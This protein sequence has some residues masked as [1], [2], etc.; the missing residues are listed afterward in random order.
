MIYA[1][2]WENGDR[3]GSGT[4]YQ[5]TPQKYYVGQWKNGHHNGQGRDV[6][7]GSTNYYEGHFVNG[8]RDGTGRLQLHDNYTYE[9]GWS[10]DEMHGF[11]KLKM[12]YKYEGNRLDEYRYDGNWD[13][14]MFHGQVRQT[15]LCG[16][17]IKICVTI[18][19]NSREQKPVI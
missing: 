1:G 19:K 4:E 10:K 6:L 17:F 2:H 18:I 16:F 11:G 13:K 15:F 7:N 12:S 5:D 9:G 3:H 14:N 8:L